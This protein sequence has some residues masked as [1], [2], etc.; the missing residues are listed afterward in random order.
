MNEIEN[1]GIQA[2]T[3]A[4]IERDRRPTPAQ[5]QSAMELAYQAGKI[6]GALET[7]TKILAG[8]SEDANQAAVRG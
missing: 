5:V 8:K 3:D 1:A 6:D 7:A 4:L 2:L